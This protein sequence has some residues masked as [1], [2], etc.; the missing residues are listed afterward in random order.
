MNKTEIL[1]LFSDFI[2]IQSVSAD[3]QRRAE[4]L[5]A[6]DFLK[7]F[8]KG[9]GFETRLLTKNNAPPLILGT[10]HLD[11][12]RHQDGRRKTIGI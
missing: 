4:I 10:Y 1:K 9:L 2:S 3:S 8:L 6:V 7:N 12:G 5:K 11:D